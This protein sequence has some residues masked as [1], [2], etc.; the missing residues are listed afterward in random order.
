MVTL[1]MFEVEVS[2]IMSV[3]RNSPSPFFILGI[4]CVTPL[5]KIALHNSPSSFFIPGI[6]CVTPLVDVALHNSHPQQSSRT[7]L[8]NSLPQ[9]SSTTVLQNSPPQQFSTTVLHKQ[10]STTV[11]QN[12]P[13]EQ[14]STTVIHNS[15]PQQP[16]TSALNNQPYALLYPGHPLCYSTSGCSPPQQ[17]SSFFIP[18]IRFPRYPFSAGPDDLVVFVFVY[19]W[20]VCLACTEI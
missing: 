18:G 10:S 7:V 11:L 12:S 3:T 17:P 5:V 13:P 15:S 8:H 16:S 4:R 6:R 19:L 14:S 9:Q 1:R 2:E 20:I